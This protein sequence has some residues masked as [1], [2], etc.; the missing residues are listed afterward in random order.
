MTVA[1]KTT[2][3]NKVYM[4]PSPTAAT[5]M[6]AELRSVTPPTTSRGTL[7]AT[8]H[9]SAAGAMEFIAEGV[10]D[11]G[12]MTLSVNYIAGSTGDTALTTAATASPPVLQNVK[13]HVKTA[14]GFQAWTFSGYVTSYG[15]DDMPVTGLQTA[16]ATIKVSGAITKAAVA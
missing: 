5:T 14:T 13:L 15:P 2:F 3:Q 1:A 8:T 11:P 4:D 16:S 6:I 12:D 10:Y 7:D 9:D